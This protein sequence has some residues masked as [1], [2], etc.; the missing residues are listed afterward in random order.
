MVHADRITVWQY[1]SSL[2]TDSPRFTNPGD[3]FAYIVFI[4]AVILVRLSCLL[5][6]L[7]V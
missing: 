6:C 3:F 2:E 1:A 7:M 4:G 5:Q